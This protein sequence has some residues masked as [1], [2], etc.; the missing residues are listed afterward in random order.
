MGTR[1]TLKSTLAIIVMGATLLGGC[2]SNG[3]RPT[4]QLSRAESLIDA[5]E[6]SGAPKYGATALE[7]ARGKLA[8]AKRA[9]DDGDN[10]EAFQ[11][12]SEAELDAR[13]AAAQA[14]RGKAE[15]ALREINASMNS[16][17][18]ETTP[19]DYQ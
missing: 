12:A 5:A 10:T 7:R 8:A 15:V 14:D 6:R 3:E 1:L 16:L 2:A 11:L 18:R 17:R 13:L 4:A 19:G 9:T